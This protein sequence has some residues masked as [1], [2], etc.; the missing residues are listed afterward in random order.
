MKIRESLTLLVF[1]TL[2]TPLFAQD[3]EPTPHIEVTG[4]ARLDIMPDEIYVSITIRE[5]EEGR[6]II[7]VESQETALKKGLQS[8]GISLDNLRLSDSESDYVKIRW[9]KKEVISSKQYVLK[10]AT[11]QEV[12]KTFEKL[13]ELKIQDAY[14]SKTERSDI[15]EL[16][17]QLRIDAIKAAK[18]KADYLLNAIG[19]ETGHALEVREN[20]QDYGYRYNSMANNIQTYTNVRSFSEESDVE[21]MPEIGFQ[22]IRLESSIYVKFE[23]KQD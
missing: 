17:K 3:K 10:L 9:K 2:F 16:R 21:V 11:A 18:E 15:V 7:D 1:I 4:T 8:I 12:S 6:D 20:I 14:I 19:E 5:R 22:K 13:D 23:I